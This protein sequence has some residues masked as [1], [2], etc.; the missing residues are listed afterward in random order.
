MISFSLNK[1]KNSIFHVKFEAKAL[2]ATEI[3]KK[4]GFPY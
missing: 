2:T 1:I 3:E 4:P